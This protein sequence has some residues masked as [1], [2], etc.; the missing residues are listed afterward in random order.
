MLFLLV[1]FPGVHVSYG[2]LVPAISMMEAPYSD[3]D[4]W[5]ARLTSRSGSIH[6]NRLWRRHRPMD[7]VCLG[8]AGWPLRQ[9][10]GPVRPD[11][12]S[13]D[14]RVPP[15]RLHQNSSAVVATWSGAFS[16]SFAQ[17][18]PDEMSAPFYGPSRARSERAPLEFESKNPLNLLSFFIFR[19]EVGAAAIQSRSGNFPRC[20]HKGFPQ[21]GN[22]R[23][24]GVSQAAFF[25]HT[26]PIG[27]YSVGGTGWR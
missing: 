21:L 23:R 18:L 22:F 27:C 6:R 19:S 3:R 15:A 17:R 20:G 5:D 12:R 25:C 14:R 16:S 7:F 24:P 4:R 13:V 10:A 11:H 8:G 9:S 2:R 26:R 1:V